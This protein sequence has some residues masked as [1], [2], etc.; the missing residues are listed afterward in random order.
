V[1][2]AAALSLQAELYPNPSHPAETVNLLVRTAQAGAATWQLKD[3][4][5]RVISQGQAEL[6]VGSTRLTLPAAELPKGV[7]LLQLRQG[8]EHLVR[9][10]VR[11]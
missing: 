6:P 3:M 1:R 5:G 9:K 8:T 11:E 10:M 7:Y 4:L 2:V